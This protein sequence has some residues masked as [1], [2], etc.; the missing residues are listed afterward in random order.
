MVL[1][2]KVPIYTQS[3]E[4]IFLHFSGDCF[5]SLRLCFDI[6]TAIA[7]A[8]I[9]RYTPHPDVLT[10]TLATSIYSITL[11]KLCFRFG[12]SEADYLGFYCE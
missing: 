1:I 2:A 3:P 8:T 9:F 12:Y 4:M 5:F 7:A 10:Y 6:H 11:E